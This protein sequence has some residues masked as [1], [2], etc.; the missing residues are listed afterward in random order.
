MSRTIRHTLPLFVVSL[1]LIA[2][3]SLAGIGVSAQAPESEGEVTV[4]RFDIAED[5]SRFYFDEAPVHENGMPNGGNTFLI[6][7]YLYPEGTLDGS[8][9][10]LPDGSPEFPDQVV[11]R[12]VC[13]GYFIND[14]PMTQTGAFAVTTQIFDLDEGIGEATIITQGFEPADMNTPMRRAITGGTGLYAGAT[15]EAFV[16]LIGFNQ[17]GA[18]NNSVELRIEH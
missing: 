11:G 16:E 13:W 14:G 5:M 8:N 18:P 12:W 10:V 7:G 17:S 3:L 2:G 9:G 15:G 1:L 6:H 4:L